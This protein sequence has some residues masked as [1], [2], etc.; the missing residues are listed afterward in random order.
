MAIEHSEITGLLSTLKCRTNFTVKKMTE[1]M[2]P[3]LKEPFYLYGADKD[4]LLVIRPAYEVFL[5][6]L[7][8]LDGVKHKAGF[9][10][11]SEMTRFPKRV[12]K[13]LN[14]IHYGLGFKFTDAAALTR[15]ITRL[16][17]INQG[18]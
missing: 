14:G 1:Y 3:E 5:A 10:H 7:S 17:A 8:A 9:V 15:F 11:H 16:I 4:C 13:S 18:H 12:Q 2:L 6:E